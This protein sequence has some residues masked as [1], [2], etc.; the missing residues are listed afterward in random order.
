MPQDRRFMW[1]A[2]ELARRGK[3]Y[4]APNPMVGCVITQ[5]NQVIGEG[6][7]EKYGQPHAEVNAM[8]AAGDGARGSTMY[9]SLEPCCEDYEGKQ[10]PPCTPQIIAAGVKRVVVAT[11]DPHPNV[12]GKGIAML[13]NA[14]ID[15]SL[16]ECGQEATEL[17]A[18]FFSLVQ[19]GRPLVTAKWA[20]TMDGKIA[21][22]SGD[23]RWISGEQ[24]RQEVHQ[25]R[26]STGA[27]IVGVN[28]AN[29]DDPEL[30]ARNVKGRQPLRVVIDTNLKLS[31]DS[32]LVKTANNQPVFVYA[33]EGADEAKA[34]ELEAVGAYVILL[35]KH[36]E[37]LMWPEILN[38]LGERKVSSVIIEGGGGIFASAFR[39]RAIDR[40]KIY[41]APKIFGGE[42]ATTPVEGP[43][44]PNVERAITFENTK[45]RTVGDD[46]VIEGQVKYPVDDRPSESGT[47]QGYGADE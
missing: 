47:W 42:D 15:V 12:R 28:T 25:D 31:M 2:L 41:M 46:V 32:K 6:Y 1:R 24:S 9:V 38:D 30:T 36:G 20:M 18:A 13:R 23:A 44:V 7:H 14:G 27:I 26:A 39:Q 8:Q 19:R 45:T 43:G 16:G 3:A 21:T 29:R 37:H 40:V 34:R 5:D 4:V 17:N 11:E 33:A 35:P 22:R 10:T